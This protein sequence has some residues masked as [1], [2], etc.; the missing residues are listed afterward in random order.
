VTLKFQ[1]GTV[2]D[3]YVARPE[4]FGFQ[5]TR[6][7]G[8][9]AHL[10]ALAARAMAKG[11]AWTDAGMSKSGAAV[12]APTEAA[13][14]KALGLALVPP[15]LR[16]G[17]GEV[18]AAASGTLPALIEPGDL[19]GFLHCHSTYSDGTSSIREWAEA[20]KAAGYA[21][22]GLTDHSKSA[23]YAGGLSP[24]DIATQ[25]AE[26]DAVNRAVPGIRIL[27][28]VEADILADGSLD[29]TPE[30]RERFEFIIA[31]IHQ[32]LGMN[33][34]EMTKRVLKA[35]DDP[36]TAI[37]GHP[38]GRLLLSRDPYPMDIDAVIKRAGERGVAIE[39]NADPQRLDLD[40]RLVRQAAASGVIISIGAD[41]HSTAAIGNAEIGLGIARKGWLT[42]DQ[43]L[44]ARPVDGF[45]AHAN[46]RRKKRKA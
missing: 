12:A 2:A 31:S 27:K 29:Y 20:A 16:E 34:E 30:I 23:A 45:L 19:K 44:N 8:N 1:S 32:R 28:G 39:I 22:L 33:G 38:T 10:E 21:Y 37:L 43:V 35:L 14:Y 4:Q 7:T 3:V 5:L 15:E 13:V 24:E 17:L 36:A 46:A 40:W 11:L 6:A 18:E 41:A 26:I 42:K 9:P 25:H